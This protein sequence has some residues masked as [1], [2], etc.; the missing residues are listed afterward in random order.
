MPLLNDI[1]LAA[2]F[3]KTLLKNVSVTNSIFLYPVAKFASIW[4]K[5]YEVLEIFPSGLHVP[6][7]AISRNVESTLADLVLNIFF[8]KPTM[9]F[10][11]KTLPV[12]W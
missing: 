9:A 1:A 10:L 11:T 12:P 2:K 5:T 4:P 8:T 3:E 7:F 6:K